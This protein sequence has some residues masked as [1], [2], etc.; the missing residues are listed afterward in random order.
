M[1]A[2]KYYQQGGFLLVYTFFLMMILMLWSQLLLNN[3]RDLYRIFAAQKNALSSVYNLYAGLVRFEQQGDC[4]TVNTLASA[5]L[6][7][8]CKLLAQ[9]NLNQHPC[10]A[11]PNPKLEKEMSKQARIRYYQIDLSDKQGHVLHAYEL[12]CDD[13]IRLSPFFRQDLY[14]GSSHGTSEFKE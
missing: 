3:H 1:Q 12:Q 8:T 4:D 13:G 7:T 6:L 9:E 2:N 11:M 14:F 10:C 5:K